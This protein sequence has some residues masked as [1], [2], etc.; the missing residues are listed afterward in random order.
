MN[1]SELEAAIRRGGY[2]IRWETVPDGGERA[3]YALRDGRRHTRSHATLLALAEYLGRVE[4][5]VRF[6]EDSDALDT[7]IATHAEERNHF[8]VRRESCR[9][10]LFGRHRYVQLIS[11]AGDASAMYELRADGLRRTSKRN[12]PPE[13][14][15]AFAAPRPDS[16]G[17]RRV[18]IR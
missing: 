18:N 13:V 3:V 10:A 17:A 14:V 16:P 8:A 7:V 6:V 9:V 1:D 11:V 5:P 12:L 15:A 4:R 2:D